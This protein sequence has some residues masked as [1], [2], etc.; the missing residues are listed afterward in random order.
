MTQFRF[1]LRSLLE[2]REAMEKMQGREVGHAD[3][4]AQEKR[5]E[6][7]A[8]ENQ[9]Q[10]VQE[11]A[12]STVGE[13]VPAGSYHV[14]GLSIAAAQVRADADAEAVREAEARHAEELKRYNEARTARRA[15]EKLRERRVA[16]WQTDEGRRERAETDEVA[17]RTIADRKD[18]P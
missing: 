17:R 12:G 6:S 10:Q 8:S 11:Q 18:K 3:S 4:A 15:L 13:M 7:H 16:D 2:L 9:L 5:D 14:M 1:R